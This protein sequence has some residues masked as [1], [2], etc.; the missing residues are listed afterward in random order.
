MA[1][2]KSS[3]NTRGL[4]DS[5][6]LKCECMQYCRRLYNQTGIAKRVGL[7]TV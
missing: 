1:V 7:R 2:F 4:R 6:V 5:R 3:F